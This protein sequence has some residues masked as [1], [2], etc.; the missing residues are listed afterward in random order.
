MKRPHGR[1]RLR[2]RILPRTLFARSLLIIAVPVILLQAIVTFI[3]FDRHWD[4]TSD[5]IV[6]ALAGEIRY[7]T[8]QIQEAPDDA[9]RQKIANDLSRSLSGLTVIFPETSYALAASAEDP[10]ARYRW[11]SVGPKLEL[12]LDR[13]LA[14]PFVV[15]PYERE[16]WFVID[17][18]YAPGKVFSVLSHERR[19]I[20]STTYIFI[21]WLI[22]SAFVLFSVSIIFMRNQ[23]RPILRLAIAAEKL[24]RGQDVPDFKPVGA[25]EVRKAAQAFIRMKDR[26]RRQIEQRTLMLAGVSHDLRT[27]LTRMKLQVAMA[28]PGSDTEALKQDIAEM[29][30]MV[31]GYLA[32]AKG[33]GDEQAVM[34]GLAAILLR[35]AANAARSG[36][37][38]DTNM[39][40]L[41]D[42]EGRFMLR[43]RPL[44][45]ERAIG[46]VVNNAC[47]YGG[48]VWLSLHLTE[49]DVEIRVDDDGPGIPAAQREAAFR[50]F[51]RL[52]KSRNKKTGGV[53][54]GLSITQDVVHAHG[55]EVILA[56]SPR[57]GLRVILRLP[58]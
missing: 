14:V 18:E 13:R 36:Y 42:H 34:G 43:M 39:G 22:G 32:F 57:G 11:F 44:A 24:G 45:I 4:N 10:F 7:I 20:S 52:E 58:A 41:L 31:D 35:V 9:A 55:G 5:K 46:N 6:S 1:V 56:D 16:K 23:I 38:I 15:R 28:P 33:E 29:E 12:D 17:V 2:H 26:L 54:L 49:D 37:K 48:Q 30:K 3:F 21:L 51:Y 27:P 19:L 40:G 53:G 8:Q 50:P 47:Q 25:M